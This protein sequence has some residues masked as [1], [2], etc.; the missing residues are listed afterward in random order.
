MS[1]EVM[2]IERSIVGSDLPFATKVRE[3]HRHWEEASLLAPILVNRDRASQLSLLLFVYQWCDESAREIRAV[4]GEEFVE[5]TEA[6]DGQA[7]YPSFFMRLGPGQQLSATLSREDRE[8]ERWQVQIRLRFPNEPGPV[9]AHWSHRTSNWTRPQV[10][11][12]LLSLLSSLER[13]HAASPHRSG[14]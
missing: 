12:L 4:Y 5:L 14:P 2:R 9:L 1:P 7:P 8:G 11:A 13:T 3:L 6:V 10:E